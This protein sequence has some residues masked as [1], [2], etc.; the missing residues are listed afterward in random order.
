MIINK[1][2]NNK[3]LQQT[4]NIWKETVE[5]S[6]NTSAKT[7]DKD[8]HKKI[9]DEIFK[10]QENKNISS[11]K[12]RVKD[13]IDILIK[14][15]V[16]NENHQCIDIGS[17]DGLYSLEFSKYFKDVTALD[18]SSVVCNKLKENMKD[19]EIKNINIINDS[20][21]DF[22]LKE[23]SYDFVFSSLNPAMTN[24]NA[25]NKMCEAS[26]KW[27]MY[28]Y[29]AGGRIS[30]MFTDLDL[31]ILGKI[32]K[33][34]GFNEIIYPF[35]ILYC[36]GYRPK[37]EYTSSISTVEINSKEAIDGLI[38]YYKKNCNMNLDIEKIIKDY[39]TLNSSDGKLTEETKWTLGILLWRV[40]E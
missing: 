6:N 19:K 8:E 5:K 9:W 39:V 10:E 30:K 31:K 14:N 7:I 23:K 33:D 25:L 15:N 12:K 21:V 34:N 28:I 17:G 24:E 26:R 36:K 3:M 32:S 20:W 2:D 1:I 18:V 4:I 29:S 40:D 35:N 38:E 16:L 13:A 22:K 27:C 37:I 11:D